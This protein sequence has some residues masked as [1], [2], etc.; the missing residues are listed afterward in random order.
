MTAD[1]CDSRARIASVVDSLWT[2][3]QDIFTD[4]N[5]MFSILLNDG[6]DDFEQHSLKSNVCLNN[7]HATALSNV[8]ICSVRRARKE[9]VKSDSICGHPMHLLSKR[10]VTDHSARLSVMHM[11]YL[12]KL[13]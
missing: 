12:R 8:L 10:Q 4:W 11:N 6:T 7:S 13:Q 9:L 1:L 2:T 3:Y 5:L